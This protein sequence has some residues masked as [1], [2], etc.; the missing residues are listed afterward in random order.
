M[1]FLK[2]TTFAVFAILILTVICF[3]PIF[4]SGFVNWDDPAY[5]LQN[6]YVLTL[7]ILT[8]IKSF[9]TSIE[10]TY[11]PLTNLSFA[12]DHALFGFNAFMF[13]WN[14]LL[15]HLANVVLV[16]LLAR[17]FGVH[18]RGALLGAFLFAI[19]PMHVEPVAWVTERKGLLSA[20]FFL[21]AMRFYI[22]YI[23][24]HKWNYY[25]FAVAAGLLSILA[26]PMGYS[27]PIVFFILDWFLKR[28]FSFKS[29]VDKCLPI[30][31]VLYFSQL[32]FTKDFLAAP[33]TIYEMILIWMWSLN[34]YLTKFLFPLG[35]SLLYDL[36]QPISLHNHEYL[37][38]T[39]VV[40]LFALMA[41]RLRKER[42]GVLAIVFFLS[43]IGALILRNGWQFGNFTVVADRFMYLPSVGFCFLVGSAVIKIFVRAK[44][45]N[46]QKLISWAVVAVLLNFSLMT[47]KQ[48]QIWKDSLT[49]WNHVIK[50]APHQSLAYVNRADYFR[51]N[52][53]VYSA[54]RDLENAIYFDPGSFMA[55]HL[56]GVVKADQ[57]K[58]KE[59]LA[60]FD[61]AHEF[62]PS[63]KDIY[64]NRGNAL[65]RLGK[66]DAALEDFNRYL[67]LA[68]MAYQGYSYRGIAHDM[69]KESDLALADFNRAL[70]IYPDYI[71]GL[72]NRG[73]FFAIQKNFPS[74]LKD[75]EQALR[76]DPKNAALSQNRDLVLQNLKLN[77]SN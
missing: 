56:L 48:T 53:N 62:N 71:E 31:I 37:L 70:E 60:A 25:G 11:V 24:E 63:F 68:P 19:H 8:I 28:T 40:F 35:L 14:N 67:E 4:A 41:L 1:N 6:P 12:V 54:E 65:L 64:L 42:L 20:F 43:T 18:P 49:L 58:L 3:F 32:T 7:N 51:Q 30:A 29:I 55:Y 47:I 66:F 9:Q 33:Y 57:G 5:V 39:V 26:K 38:S 21:L 23:Q 77:P 44:D 45:A 75:F 50:I 13:H 27:F 52:G 2:N 74:A 46:Q 76:L 69:R 59:A 72:T 15:I 17:Q 36:P 61:Q 16:F 34:F 73:T 22:F 10:H